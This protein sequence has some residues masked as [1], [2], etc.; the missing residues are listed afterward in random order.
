M[1]EFFVMQNFPDFVK[2]IVGF[3]TENPDSLLG[4]IKILDKVYGLDIQKGFAPFLE[5]TK[6]SMYEF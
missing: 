3:F 5:T 4:E 6:T 1:K 2:P